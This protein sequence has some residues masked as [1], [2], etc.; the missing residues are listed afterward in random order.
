MVRKMGRIPRTLFRGLLSRTGRDLQLDR[1]ELLAKVGE[2]QTRLTYME[3][4][5]MGHYH[6]RWNA[7]VQAADY[8]VGARIPGDYAEFGVYQGTTFSFA[9][10]TMAS[11]FPGMRF[12]AFDSFEGL[13]EPSGIDVT[14]AYS[15]SFEKGQFSCSYE[16]FM[17]NLEQGAVNMERI[18]VVKGWFHKSLREENRLRYGIDK[19]AVAWVDCDLYE[20]TVPVLKFIT[21]SLSV[22]SVILFDDWRCFRNLPDFGQQRACS[23]WLSE[24][25][26]IKLRHLLSF[27]WHGNAFTVAAC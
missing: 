20:S 18:V 22:G 4:R 11:A 16:D 26:H 12:L 21:P 24:N 27:G 10:Q 13:P 1:D 25:P 14:N 2:L 23:E 19:I 15:S 7:V 8:L 6:N 9:Y 5:V 3:N 17:R